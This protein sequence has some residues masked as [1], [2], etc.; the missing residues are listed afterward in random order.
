MPAPEALTASSDGSTVLGH[1]GIDHPV[2]ISQTPRTPHTDEASAQPPGGD[3]RA[4]AR[5]GRQGQ[6]MTIRSPGWTLSEPV[7]AAIIATRG[8][9][10][11]PGSARLAMDH[12]ESPGRTV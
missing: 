11:P 8:R 7:R 5:C 3:R 10:S 9:G 1:A 4:T 12:S 2:V 6:G